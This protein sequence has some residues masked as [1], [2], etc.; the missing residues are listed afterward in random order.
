MNLRTDYIAALGLNLTQAQTDALLA[1]ADL[2]WEKRTQLNLTSVADKQEIW[3]RHILDGL[4]AAAQI[5]KL[6]N[7]GACSAADYGSGAGYIGISIKIALANCSVSLVESLQRRC[8]FLE[9]VIFKLGLKNINVANVRAGQG[10]DGGPFDFTTERAMGKIDDVL[11]LCT[12]SLKP[13]GFFI[14]YQA[15]AGEYDPKNTLKLN[16]KEQSIINYTLPCDGVSRKLVIFKK[17][18][19][20]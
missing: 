13:E 20:N 11:P 18:G 16:I 4:T 7:G 10:A 6:A 9:W 12:A 14:A 1:Y 5:N 19:H 3:D 8:M 2:V 17:Y 15:Q